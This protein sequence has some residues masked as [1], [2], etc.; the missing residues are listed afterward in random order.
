MEMKR[1]AWRFYRTVR[2]FAIL[3]WRKTGYLPPDIDGR[4]SARTAWTVARGLWQ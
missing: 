2:L 1:K 3:V 4:I